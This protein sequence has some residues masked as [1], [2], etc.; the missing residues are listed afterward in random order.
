MVATSSG[1]PAAADSKA[2]FAWVSGS[3]AIGARLLPGKPEVGR[4]ERGWMPPSGTAKPLLSSGG[5]RG[6]GAGRVVITAAASGSIIVCNVHP[7]KDLT[8]VGGNDNFQSFAQLSTPFPR[9]SAARCARLPMI[10][11][12]RTRHQPAPSAS[13]AFSTMPRRGY[14]SD[15]TRRGVPG[16]PRRGRSQSGDASVRDGLP[17]DHQRGAACLVRMLSWAP[18]GIRRDESLISPGGATG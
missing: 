15:L 1:A 2:L 3:L 18:S 8:S 17:G 11:F 6:S 10:I 13:M 12:Q 5:F 16:L 7:R 9:Q 4:V 14:Q